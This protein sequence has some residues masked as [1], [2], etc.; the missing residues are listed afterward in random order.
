MCYMTISKICR[1]RGFHDCLVPVAPY[2]AGIFNKLRTKQK[3]P[4]KVR[5]IDMLHVLLLLHFILEGLLTE[6]V[7]E[8]N[9]QNPFSRICDPSPIVINLISWYGLYHRRIPAKDE[10]DIQDLDT[11]GHRYVQYIQ[12]TLCIINIFGILTIICDF[13]QFN[14][15]WLY[16]QILEQV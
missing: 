16:V 2:L 8:Y 7:A 13:Q 3:L 6:E 14:V 1:L 9:R 5:A 11:L 12:Y 15:I 10:D 4:W